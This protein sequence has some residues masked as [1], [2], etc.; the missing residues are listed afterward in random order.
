MEE[1]IRTGAKAGRPDQTTYADDMD[2]LDKLKK[3]LCREAI[4]PGVGVNVEV[5]R[6]CESQCAFGRKY[7][8]LWDAGERPVKRG[9]PKAERAD[10]R[11]GENMPSVRKS[12]DEVTMQEQLE[13]KLRENMELLDVNRKLLDDLK[14][15]DEQLAEVS[16]ELDA[17]QAKC[18]AQQT[19]LWKLKAR[20]Y[21]MEH[22]EEDD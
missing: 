6:N 10:L 1:R 20:L 12:C 19:E 3:H 16:R 22:P 9:R 5:C 2:T 17:R 8:H 4:K 13:A 15:V 18:K 11:E 14:A 21:D 7:V